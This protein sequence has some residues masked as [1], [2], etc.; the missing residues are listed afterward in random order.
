MIWG[1]LRLAHDVGP[2]AAKLHTA[3]KIANMRAGDCERPSVLVLRL[4]NITSQ[5]EW[6]RLQ[7]TTDKI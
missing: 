1:D 2:L 7:A 3:R 4:I 6:L 5:L